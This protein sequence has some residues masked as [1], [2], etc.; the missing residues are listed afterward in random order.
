MQDFRNLQV[1]NKAMTLARNCYLA[2]D[3]FPKHERFGL[4]L[5]MRKSAVSVPSNI[6]EGC[7]RGSDRDF[8]RFLRIAYGSAC[9]VE[10]QARIAVE[11]QVGDV[12]RLQTVISDAQETRRMISGLIARTSRG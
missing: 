4:V 9:E 5:Q 6:A 2:T 8:T 3:T 11:V 10:T 7:G 12:A 1:W